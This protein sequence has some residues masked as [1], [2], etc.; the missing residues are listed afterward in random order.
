MIKRTFLLLM[1]S[2]ICW[3][4]S[5]TRQIDYDKAV[6]F[7]DIQSFSLDLPVDSPDRVRSTILSNSIEQNLTAKGLN[8]TE[9]SQSDIAVSYFAVTSKSQVIL[10]SLLD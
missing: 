6:S 7:S 3:G 10:A 1:V 5:T 8:K 9:A 2:V 4:C